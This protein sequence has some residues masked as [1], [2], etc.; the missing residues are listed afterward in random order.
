MMDV[1]K[2]Y[3]VFGMRMSIPSLLNINVLCTGKKSRQLGSKSLYAQ[4]LRCRD[5]CSQDTRLTIASVISFLFSEPPYGTGGKRDCYN[6]LCRI[7]CATSTVNM[8]L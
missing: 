1:G 4:C 3:T 8:T 2:A 5:S 6:F 7:E